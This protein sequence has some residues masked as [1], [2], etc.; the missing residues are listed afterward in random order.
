M[1]KLMRTLEFIVFE[2]SPIGFEDNNQ[3]T[4]DRQYIIIH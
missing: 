4:E 3:A 1:D 2:A